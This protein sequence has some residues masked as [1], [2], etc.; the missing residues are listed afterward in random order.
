M[1]VVLLHLDTLEDS[2]PAAPGAADCLQSAAVNYRSP[3]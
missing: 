2:A 1:T 3:G